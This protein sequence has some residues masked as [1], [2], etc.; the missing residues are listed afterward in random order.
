MFFARFFGLC[1]LPL[2]MLLLLL[3]P[4]DFLIDNNGF[5]ALCICC[6]LLSFSNPFLRS[7][8]L[9]YLYTILIKLWHTHGDEDVE[10]AA[11]AA[12]AVVRFLS[13][14]PCANSSDELQYLFLRMQVPQHEG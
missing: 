2:M 11:A 13:L 10:A 5:C 7:L 8:E 6:R 1:L 12:T 3:L 4:L 14:L 9:L